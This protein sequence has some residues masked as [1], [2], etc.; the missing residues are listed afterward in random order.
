MVPTDPLW[1]IQA[2]ESAK[3]LANYQILAKEL[4]IC[5][6]PGTIIEKHTESDQ[7][8]LFHNT[9]Y[10]ISND[11]T[12]LGSYRKKNICIPGTDRRRRADCDCA[13]LLY[14]GLFH[15]STCDI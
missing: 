9:A 10:F 6:V 2:G 7:P 13:Y 4:Q 15:A 14:V 12:V 3:Y 8:T 11:G 1:A 5:I